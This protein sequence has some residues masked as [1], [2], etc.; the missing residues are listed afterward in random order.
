MSSISSESLDALSEV[1][2][3][4]FVFVDGQD[5]DDLAKTPETHLFRPRSASV[6]T[7][8]NALTSPRSSLAIESL[9]EAD[10]HPK[11]PRQEVPPDPQQRVG[12]M[13]RTEQKKKKLVKLMGRQQSIEMIVPFLVASSVEEAKK[14]RECV[15]KSD[16]VKHRTGN[17]PPP[18]LLK[19][20]K[21]ATNQPSPNTA[22]LNKIDRF[23]G[24]R[25]SFS[26]VS[27]LLIVRAPVSPAVAH[28]RGG[29]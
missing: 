12:D 27:D 6:S 11:T 29:V 18:K 10:L 1:N 13:Q 20:E 4:F 24:R 8:S 15:I 26:A 2:D 3:S 22:K 16:C 25:K 21:Q 17:R 23:F 19:E 14:N 9:Y 28:R 5:L 7:L